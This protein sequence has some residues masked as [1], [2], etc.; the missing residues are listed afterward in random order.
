V[1]IAECPPLSPS[2]YSRG[3][4][5]GERSGC[6]TH[7]ISEKGFEVKTQIRLDSPSQETT[8]KT[9]SAVHRET[10]L[11]IKKKKT[12]GALI[13]DSLGLLDN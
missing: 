4:D 2:F 3:G 8:K 5:A 12:S 13:P 10:D 7:K 11:A 1:K 9:S 6:N